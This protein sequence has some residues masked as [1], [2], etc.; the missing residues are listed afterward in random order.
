MLKMYLNTMVL[1]HIIYKLEFATN[2]LKVQ[3]CYLQFDKSIPYFLLYC[4]IMNKN[5]LLFLT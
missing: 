3:K 5:K 2:M 4:K 1:H